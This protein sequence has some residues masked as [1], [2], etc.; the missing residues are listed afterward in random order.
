MNARRS[1]RPRLSRLARLAR[2][3]RRVT[4]ASL[5]AFALAGGCDAVDLPTWT[6][7]PPT[8]E[9]ASVERGLLF[10][11]DAP[12]PPCGSCSG[13]CGAP[14]PQGNCYCDAVCTVFGDCCPDIATACPAPGASCADSCGGTSPDGSCSCDDT[15]STNGDCCA[16]KADVCPRVFNVRTAGEGLE[17]SYLTSTG[18][19]M[20]RVADYHFLVTAP[21]FEGPGIKLFVRAGDTW[22]DATTLFLPA[23]VGVAR[24]TGR[25]FFGD[26][27]NDEQPDLLYIRDEQPKVR[28][29]AFIWNRVKNRFD[30][31]PFNANTLVTANFTGVDNNGEELAT[32]FNNS[33][34]VGIEIAEKA[35]S[36]VFA[37]MDADG[38]DDL[39]VARAGLNLVF[40]N[41]T[42]NGAT[43]RSGWIPSGVVPAPPSPPFKR[44]IVDRYDV[45]N[46]AAITA[47]AL[48]ANVLPNSPGV[49]VAAADARPGNRQ[50]APNGN[51]YLHVYGLNPEAATC[52]A[53][54]NQICEDGE[55]KN[56]A[57]CAAGYQR[58]SCKF[59]DRLHL[60]TTVS[61]TS[62]LAV[63][64]VGDANLDLLIFGGPERGA[65]T[66]FAA[67]YRNPADAACNT[68]THDYARKIVLPVNANGTFGAEQAAP[69]PFSNLYTYVKR[70]TTA[71]LRAGEL[72]IVTYTP[73]TPVAAEKTPLRVT[74]VTGGLAAIPI[75]HSDDTDPTDADIAA[76]DTDF[77]GLDDLHIMNGLTNRTYFATGTGTVAMRARAPITRQNLSRPIPADFD[78]D[79][80]LD[81]FVG[82]WSDTVSD[83]PAPKLYLNNGT[84]LFDASHLIPAHPATA[85]NAQGVLQNKNNRDQAT[86]LEPYYFIHGAVAFDMDRDGDLDIV[87]SSSGPMLVYKNLLM[88]S[89]NGTLAFELR[90]DLLPLYYTYGG[91]INGGPALP[92][93]TPNIVDTDRDREIDDAVD[94]LPGDGNLRCGGKSLQVADFDGNGYQDLAIGIRKGRNDILFYNP[95]ASAT[96]LS[97]CASG[98]APWCPRTGF[99][100]ARDD[101]RIGS[102]FPSRT[103]AA[104]GS[105]RGHNNRTH[106]LLAGYFDEGNFA[107]PR[108]PDI[109][110][111][112]VPS[113]TFTGAYDQL[114]VNQISTVLPHAWAFCTSGYAASCAAGQTCCPATLPNCVAINSQPDAKVCANAQNEVW[115]DGWSFPA[116]AD[117][118]PTRDDGDTASLFYGL[119]AA[120]QGD[121]NG[122]GY[123]DFV[124]ATSADDALQ[125]G[126]DGTLSVLSSDCHLTK[127]PDLNRDG[128]VVDNNDPTDAI[129]DEVPFPVCTH[130][131]TCYPWRCR[132]TNPA[133][134]QGQTVSVETDPSCCGTAASG[135][136]Y[137]PTTPNNP[138]APAPDAAAWYSPPACAK[139]GLNHVGRCDQRGYIETSVRPEAK[140]FVYL[141]NPF[142]GRFEK[143]AQP[144]A[145]AQADQRSSLLLSLD[146]G[147]VDRDGDLDLVVAG[148][149][150]GDMPEN[151]ATQADKPLLTQITMTR[152]RYRQVEPT[153]LWLNP[154]WSAASSIYEPNPEPFAAGNLVRRSDKIYSVVF[155]D[156]DNDQ[157]LEILTGTAGGMDILDE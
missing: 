34:T 10:C 154:G 142:T 65:E 37:D 92:S 32:F 16:D 53:A 144:V 157:R 18:S 30:P 77:D 41:L 123:P 106:L 105:G 134:L 94:G 6:E 15:C 42:I 114:F 115:Y 122:D 69:A 7:S 68:V 1:K 31:A 130:V 129:A 47:A 45:V 43:D 79:G 38:D 58:L 19:A 138:N 60:P 82:T 9:P 109:V 62:I 27:N 95:G 108:K 33:T 148:Y 24:E 84:R 128:V 78:N 48:A 125:P 152:R 28:A 103:E 35:L 25:V 40:E 124:V 57:D 90:Q 121:L 104:P 64:L 20:A 96:G 133:G 81:V 146:L 13:Q 83:K 153:R 132:A 113:S 73:T 126:L 120:K 107:T 75:P 50:G 14:T 86:G 23:E 97:G 72:S 119:S 52:P 8:V 29:L 117:A 139:L 99:L 51:R 151:Y 136:N 21:M 61:A 71:T 5:F 70:A 110:A 22:A 156:I 12:L 140:L 46:D 44:H 93:C 145:L 98:S 112:A 80:R 135:T 131:A 87:A 17:P 127:P 147:D 39:F 118:V 63:D 150:T 2:R 100:S 54:N 89:G 143:K 74:R 56:A 137:T 59:R 66:T 76:L 101:L 141:F 102:I 26:L 4:L 155:A 11:G 36:V 3:A 149:T 91:S 88:E 116:R 49:E 55:P 85:T 111:L 67:C